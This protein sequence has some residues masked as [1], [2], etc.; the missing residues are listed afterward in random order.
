MDF[1]PLLLRHS[2]YFKG[3][4]R[5]P[6]KI[7]SILFYFTQETRMIP[8]QRL[9]L[10]SLKSFWFLK[11]LQNRFQ[12]IIYPNYTRNQFR[13]HWWRK[14]CRWETI[15]TIVTGLRKP[16]WEHGHCFKSTKHKEYQDFAQAEWWCLYV[17]IRPNADRYDFINIK[18][19]KA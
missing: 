6:H 4:T 14:I 16:L 13:S 12:T 8:E 15:E 11:Q 1:F 7:Q 17:R 9:Q 10:L 18:K 3:T 19:H 5:Y 2:F